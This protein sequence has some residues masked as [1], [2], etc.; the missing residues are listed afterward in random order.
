WDNQDGYIACGGDDGMLKVLK[1]ESLGS[2]NN[3]SPAGD[4]GSQLSMNQTLEGHSGSVTLSI[5][6]PTHQKLTTADSN[7]LIIVWILYKG[8]W[9]EEMINNRNKSV[10]AS[11][12][13]NR[14][15]QRICIAYQDGAVILG[16]VDGNRIWGK[17][18]KEQLAHVAWSPDS[19]FILFATEQGKI[20][21]YD[22]QGNV[23]SKVSNF[24]DPNSKT[25]IASMDWYNGSGG[26]L[27]KDVPCLAIAF[28]NGKMQ[29]M[30]GHSDPKPILLDTKL[31]QLKLKWSL[32]GAILAVAG[33]QKIQNED[34]CAVQLWSPSGQLYRFLKVPG[35]KLSCLSWEYV[36]TR[37]ALSVDSFV[38]FANIRRNYKWATVAQDVIVYTFNQP[39][40]A[41]N[42]IVF[43]NH[44][45]N[46]KRI[47]TLQGLVCIAADKEHCLLVTKKDDG[48]SLMVC[49]SIGT[50]LDTKNIPFVPKLC[51]ISNNDV[52]LASDAH[53]Y[54]WS[55]KTPTLGKIGVIEA[56]RRK[57]VK[58]RHFLIDDASIVGDSPK[59]LD[60]E[61]IKS[62]TTND[63]IVGLGLLDS[64]LLVG[65]QSGELLQ[66]QLPSLSLSNK[67]TSDI[68]PCHLDINCNHT[69][70]AVRDQQG[71]L[72]IMDLEGKKGSRV[73]LKSME[74]NRKDVWDLLWSSDQADQL[75]VIEKNKLLVIEHQLV[76]DPILCNGYLSNFTDLT[77]KSVS[78]DDILNDPM[79]PTKESV[80]A[81]E[82]KPLVD[83]RVLISQHGVE[84]AFQLAENIHHPKIWKVVAEAALEQL[85][86]TTATKA[87]V[88]C[89]DYH[90]IQFIKRIQKI[91]DTTIQ[92]AEIAAFCN[93]MDQAE[94][95]YMD[96]DRKDLAMDL[97]MRMGDW[98]RVVQIIK[99]GGGGDDQLLEKAWNHIGNYYFERQKY[100]Q[101]VQYYIQGRNTS[102]LAQAYFLLEDYENLEKLSSN[103]SENSQD[104]KE[105]A[106]HFAAAGLCEQAVT[107]YMKAGD[108]SAAVNTCVVL[109]QWNTAVELARLHN[110]K[111]IQGLLQKYASYL[112]EQNRL[113]EAI[114]LFRK[115]NWCHKSAQLLFQMA[116][117][118][119][120]QHINPVTIKQLYV[121]GA[122]EIERLHSVQKSQVSKSMQD[123]TA[124]LDAL[125][126][127][128]KQAD[129]KLLTNPW[130]GA[131]A[132]HF[133]MLAQRHFYQGNLDQAVQ[134]SLLLRDYDDFIGTTVA[135]SLI[136]LTSLHAGHFQTCSKALIVL[137]T[138]GSKD[139]Q[140]YKKLGLSIFK[141]NRPINPKQRHTN[142]S[143]CLAR[144]GEMDTQCHQ[145]KMV[146]PTCIASGRPI[147]ESIHFMCQTCKHRAL[148]S[149][150]A[151]FRCCPLVRKMILVPHWTLGSA[152]VSCLFPFRH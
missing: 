131:E 12:N 60:F 102:K 85:D 3:L 152:L 140:Y 129:H 35:K 32:D 148:E 22:N 39:E 144:I 10:V 7:G 56:L 25:K 92:K 107:A 59:S 112:T 38:F 147:V 82:T 124:A 88:Q 99:T 142:C 128:D 90:G 149:E 16:S 139:V 109:N 151:N 47:K 122:L 2:A 73:D 105:I 53:L 17:E 111:E 11:M 76:H 36:G 21:L 130:R 138:L 51:K 141:E 63:P 70:V 86:F 120:D 135:Y 100:A 24:I 71:I 20:T 113:W 52:V 9:Y 33:M 89:Q 67:Y 54:H 46:D 34:Q 48:A 95:I 146:F 81:I 26:Y 91:R 66:F 77:V 45:T 126:Q 19:R 101:A 115:A 4:K 97:H 94:K 68:T 40:S 64:C 18:L 80:T 121:L 78:L 104:L 87:L 28:E 50:T 37:L 5:W 6:N 106:G 114:E 61:F 14:D 41:D 23:V 119:Q 132:W 116:K 13:W 96:G 42:E 65:R 110:F 55:F 75:A 117:K 1:L 29:L 15:G 30:R 150:I 62:K 72:K 134:T 74:L 136:A 49:N 83:A 143:N 103:L 118:G 127:E 137:E 123:P 108:I 69:R 84:N 145:C 79:T 44:K 58:E 98:F 43:W 8:M 31:D 27:E 133:Y 125:L 57:E 93:K